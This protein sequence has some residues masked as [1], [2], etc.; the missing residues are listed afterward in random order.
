MLD[1]SKKSYPS[2]WAARGTRLAR[3]SGCLPVTWSKGSDRVLL[4]RP[5]QGLAPD[6]EIEEPNSTL[7]QKQTISRPRRTGIGSRG[8]MT[9]SSRSSLPKK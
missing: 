1:C 6:L 9:P 4:V 8:G 3:D 5:L 2:R 7:V